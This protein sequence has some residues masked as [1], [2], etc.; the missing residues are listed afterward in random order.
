VARSVADPE[1]LRRLR[2]NRDVLARLAEGAARSAD[3]VGP[4]SPDGWVMQTHPDLAD[5]LAAAADGTGLRPA[6]VYGVAILLDPTDRIMAV[7]RG[8]SRA[9]L[10]IV[11]G[12]AMSRLDEAASLIPGLADFVAVDAWRVELRDWVDASAILVGLGR[13]RDA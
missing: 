10:R 1:Q 13:R 5:A 8:T 11:D 3:G 9:W 6:V 4:W 7:G 2:S 12:P